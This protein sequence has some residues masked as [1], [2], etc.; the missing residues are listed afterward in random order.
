MGPSTNRRE[1]LAALCHAQWSGWM[2][3]L[4]QR[5]HVCE[6]GSAVIPQEWYKRWLRQAMI[7]YADLSEAERESDRIEADRILAVLNDSPPVRDSDVDVGSDV[8]GG[9]AI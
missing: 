4:Y 6:D 7:P 8:P 1:A 3:Y 5:C 9:G 2:R